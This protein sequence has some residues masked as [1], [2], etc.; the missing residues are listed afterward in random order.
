MT[1][2]WLS[3][4]GYILVLGMLVQACTTDL[5]DVKAITKEY[6]VS[7]DIGE[8]VK[9][10]YSDSALVKMTIDAPVLERYNDL[11][12]PKDVFPKGILISF[13]GPNRKPE[14]W[15]T[16]SEA[17]REPKKRKMTVRGNVQFYNLKNDKLQTSE[18]IYDE[19]L[20]KIYT[21]KFIRITR[22]SMG[23][24]IYG[25]GFETD[26]NFNR[27]EIKQKIKGKLAGGEF[28]PD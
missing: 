13:L 26:Q 12:E 8:K 19:N 28:I 6:D 9:I 18:L 25:I 4:F 11:A 1:L 16:A 7:K 24:T 27:I 15:L 23:D 22:P 14:S 5:N 21:E 2:Q 17:I 20:R 10:I 3:K